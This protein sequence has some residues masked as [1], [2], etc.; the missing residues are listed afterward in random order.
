LL[1]DG[2]AFVAPTTVRGEVVGRLVFLHPG[3]PF[4]VIEE[5]AATLA[6]S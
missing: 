4:S 5:I 2:V 1:H 6:R 3:T